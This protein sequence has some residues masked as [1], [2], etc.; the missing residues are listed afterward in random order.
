VDTD[1]T[2]EYDT[3]THV[4]LKRGNDSV[5]AIRQDAAE[6]WTSSVRTGQRC[7]VRTSFHSLSDAHV[8]CEEQ[9]ALRN[10]A[11]R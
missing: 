9:V 2:W 5:I 7:A 1:S 8:W 3:G 6:R 10:E 11:A 4:Y